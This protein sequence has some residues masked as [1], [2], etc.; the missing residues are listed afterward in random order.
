MTYEEFKK[1]LYRNISQLGILK[2]KEII[3]FEKRKNLVDRRNVDLIKE[4]N[5][6]RYGMRSIL[7]DE[8]LLCIVWSEHGKR[9]YKFWSVAELYK[10]YLRTGWNDLIPEIIS[11]LENDSY[12]KNRERLILRPVNYVNHTEELLNCVF[13]GIGDSIALVLYDVIR[14]DRAENY[15]VK[16]NREMMESWGVSE[17]SVLWDALLNTKKRMPPRLFHAEGLKRYWFQGEE[18]V[19]MPDDGEI[20]I[21]VNGNNREERANG[22]RLTTSLRFG[23]AIALFYPGVKEQIGNLLGSDYYV[24]LLHTDEV[25]IYPVVNRA[26]ECLRKRIRKAS[27]FVDDKYMLSSSIFRYS[28]A[29][30]ELIEI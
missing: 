10:D 15:M 28:V 17:Y 13:W 25:M 24:G 26:T 20:S 30:N 29:R 12:D 3:M 9:R 19:F 11:K 16:V 1:E 23:G 5:Y 22:Y 4:I 18:G 6:C 21:Q 7:I 2:Y 14:E 27:L 8:D